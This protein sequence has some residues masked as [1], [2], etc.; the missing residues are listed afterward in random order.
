MI[1]SVRG[2]QFHTSAGQVGIQAVRLGVVPDE[3]HGEQLDKPRREGCVDQV[4]SCDVA[5]SM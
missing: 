2:D 4:T 3:T 5:L 1:C